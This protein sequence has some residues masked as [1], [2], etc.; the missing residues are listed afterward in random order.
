M[1]KKYNLGNKSD[2]RKFSKDLENTVIDKAKRIA[3]NSVFDILCPH[4]NNSISA[5]A[6]KSLCTYWGKEINVKLNIN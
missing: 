4:C 5:P 6:G 1:A 2:M 3:V